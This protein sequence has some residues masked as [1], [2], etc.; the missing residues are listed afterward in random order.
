M[1]YQHHLL[2]WHLS[3]S[4]DTIYLRN[5]MISNLWFLSRRQ[6]YVKSQG[7]IL[8]KLEETMMSLSSILSFY[9]WRSHI[10]KKQISLQKAWILK[11]WSVIVLTLSSIISLLPYMLFK[12][13]MFP[14]I[15]LQY[16]CVFIGRRLWL[17]LKESPD[18]YDSNV[19][20][21]CCSYHSFL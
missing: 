4:P 8:L 20:T 6:I 11:I 13:I 21:L 17:Y 16:K 12:L 10:C 3:L 2:S 7:H 15:I 5:N 14:A 19:C 18:L 9:K 1:V